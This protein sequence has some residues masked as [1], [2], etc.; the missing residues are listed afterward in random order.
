MSK[1][2]KRALVFWSGPAF[3][4]VMGVVYLVAARASGQPELGLVLLIIM[5]VFGGVMVIVSRYS[6]TVRGLLDRRDERI[7]RIDLR[8]TAA[9][10]LAL[11]LAIGAGAVYELSQGR[12]GTPYTWLALLSAVVYVGAVVVLRIKR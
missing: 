2:V 5:V 10:G 9:A 3:C 1:N 4:L 12:D 6:E 8:A 11:V 7:T